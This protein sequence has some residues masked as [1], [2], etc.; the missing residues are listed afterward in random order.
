MSNNPSLMPILCQV[1]LIFCAVVATMITHFLPFIVF[2]SSR[3]TPRI[4]TFLGKMLPSSVFALL[5]I[6]CLR[7]TDF[8]RLLTAVFWQSDAFAQLAS[9]FATVLI[10]VWKRN[11]TW[12]IVVG[13]TCYM[14]LTRLT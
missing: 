14:I 6:Y 8:T 2:R 1:V 5:V 4:V 11:M 13:T 10:H 7:G 9:V 3:H 12:S